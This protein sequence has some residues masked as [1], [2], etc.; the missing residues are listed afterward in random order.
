MSPEYKGLAIYQS[1]L[2]ERKGLILTGE[3]E[4]YWLK[5]VDII[6]IIKPLHI[7][8]KYSA[9]PFQI[10]AIY[11]DEWAGPSYK[12]IVGMESYKGEFTER[13]KQDFEQLIVAA[14]EKLQKS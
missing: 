4:S 3:K 14:I 8:E 6:L 10:N 7:K 11:Y 9:M 12:V 13:R 5:N 2:I 1:L